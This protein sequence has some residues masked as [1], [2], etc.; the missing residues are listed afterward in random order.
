MIAEGREL[1]S[2]KEGGK[3]RVYE[4]MKRSVIDPLG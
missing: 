2:L 4:L 1:F 3:L